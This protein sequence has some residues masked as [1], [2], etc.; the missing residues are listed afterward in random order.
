MLDKHHIDVWAIWMCVLVTL[1]PQVKDGVGR[2]VLDECEHVGS[3]LAQA[4]LGRDFGKRNVVREPVD[5]QG[6]VDAKGAE[7]AAFVAV[8][9][10]SG[11]AN[12]PAVNAV[13]CHVVALVGTRWLR[14]VTTFFA[15]VT[16]VNP[17]KG[18]VSGSS[19]KLHIQDNHAAISSAS[20]QTQVH[21][22][23]RASSKRDSLLSCNPRTM[24]R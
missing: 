7:D 10:L 11:W 5:G 19:P 15:C 22:Q 9:V 16:E 12:V 1:E 13:G 6:V 3:R 14:Q 24:A 23:V 2:F 17:P 8:A 20:Q 18:K 4:F 21:E